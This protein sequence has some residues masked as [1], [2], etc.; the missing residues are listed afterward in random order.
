MSIQKEIKNINVDEKGIKHDLI[1][2]KDSLLNSELLRE[3]KRK[4]NYGIIISIISNL[5]GAIN[6]LQLKTYPKW[7]KKYYSQ[8][9]L[10]FYRS[11]SSCLICYYLIKKKNQTIPRW[12]EIN[13]KFWFICRECGGYVILLLYLEMLTYFRVSTCQCIFGIHPIFVLLLSIVVIL[14]EIN[15]NQRKQ[16]ENKSVFIG[17]LFS[18]GYLAALCFSKFAQKMLCKDHMTPGVQTYYIGLFTALQALFF[19][20][21]DFQPGLNFIYIIYALSNGIIFTIYNC[22]CVEAMNNLAIS[23]YL[24]LTYFTTVFIFIFG[25]IILGERVYFT[26]IIGSLLIIGFQIYNA[27]FPTINIKK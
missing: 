16:S 26:D 21:F 13:N 3:K 12:S 20:L 6:Q 2:I 11:F 8:N 9:N 25:W 1:S 24:P 7:F 5:A 14:N 4:E 15:P 19:L 22:L 27:W 17:I 23:K 10:L 18:M